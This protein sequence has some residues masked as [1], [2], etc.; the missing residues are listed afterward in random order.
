MAAP[1]HH[2]ISSV[3]KFGGKVADYFKIHH[4]FDESKA[5]FADLRHRALRHHSMGI[6]EA[7]KLFGD[8]LDGTIINSDGNKVPVR[9]IGEQ[10]VK[11][12]LG[13]IPSVSDWLKH[14]SIEHW[15]TRTDPTVGQKEPEK[16][17]PK[18]GKKK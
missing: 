18:V 3:K 8:P 2:S 4:W 14:I 5:Q 10:H 7:E 9:L 12:D 1:Y 16:P 15:M 6:F 11:E 17:T 13:H